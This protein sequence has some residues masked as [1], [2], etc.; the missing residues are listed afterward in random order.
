MIWI[1][2]KELLFKFKKKS[3]DVYNHGFIKYLKCHSF[4]IISHTVQGNE[5]ATGI[6]GDIAS[7]PME[8]GT[9]YKRQTINKWTNG[10]NFSMKY[11]NKKSMAEVE[12]ILIKEGLSGEEIF[13]LTSEW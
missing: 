5:Y 8:I 1:G 10:Y 13:N 12:E 2:L 6:R 11:N 3:I 9:Q 4:E 7:A